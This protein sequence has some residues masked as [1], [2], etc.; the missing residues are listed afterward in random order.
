MSALQYQHSSLSPTVQ[1]PSCASRFAPFAIQYDP[2]V[3]AWHT[4]ATMPPSIQSQARLTA[5]S[6]NINFDSYTTKVR[7]IYDKYSSSSGGTEY[8]NAGSAIKEIEAMVTTIK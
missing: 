2:A 5:P 4:N 7:K 6:N 3:T 1:C 8:K